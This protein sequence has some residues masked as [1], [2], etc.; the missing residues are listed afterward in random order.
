MTDP[1]EP[2]EQPLTPHGRQLRYLALIVASVGALEGPPW[3]EFAACCYI[4]ALL[5]TVFGYRD[6]PLA[7]GPP[8]EPDEPDIGSLYG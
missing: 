7:Y 3:L 1:I 4:V 8:D 2:L 6:D 5:W